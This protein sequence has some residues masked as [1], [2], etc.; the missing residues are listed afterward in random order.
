MPGRCGI[1][2]VRQIRFL[3]PVF[4]GDAITVDYVIAHIDLTKRRAQADI[5]VINQDGG[6]VAVA[7]HLL[8]WTRE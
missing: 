3:K 5:T 6:V 4:I 7:A 8:H 2:R 1:G